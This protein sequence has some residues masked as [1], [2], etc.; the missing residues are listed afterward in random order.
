[1][2][3]VSVSTSDMTITAQG[4]CIWKDIDEA[5]GAHGLATVGGTVNHTGIGGLTLGGGY[6]WLSGTYGMVIDNLLSVDMVLAD[7]SQVTA[8]EKENQDLFWALRGAGTAFGVATSFTYRAHPQEHHVWA[9]TMMWPVAAAEAI[10]NF[11]NLHAESSKGNTGFAIGI[12]APPHFGGEAVILTAIFFNG[13]QAEGEK[14]FAPLLEME[15]KPL[16][17]AMSERPYFEVNSMLNAA[18]G[19][20]FRRVTKGTTFS[21]PFSPS[22]FMTL[23]NEFKTLAERF[24]EAGSSLIILEYYHTDKICAVEQTA[25]AFANRGRYQNAVIVPTWNNEELDGQMR[26][27]ARMMAERVREGSRKEKGDGVG[28]Y[29]NYDALGEKAEKVYGQNYERLVE[30]KRR[31]DSENVFAKSVGLFPT[32]KVMN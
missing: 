22:H 26:L 14:V 10:V 18:A 5:A 1:M 3:N 28:E 24:P 32:V 6:G 31:Y 20:G 27:W 4:G 15:I 29:A 7:G 2:R 12:T 25:T 11:G 30:L 23:L 16:H 21:T 17:N 9:G 13:S 8:S 19:H